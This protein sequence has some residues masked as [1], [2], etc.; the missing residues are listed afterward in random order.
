MPLVRHAVDRSLLLFAAAGCASAPAPAPAQPTKIDVAEP[1]PDAAAEQEAELAC[2]PA[3]PGGTRC[4]DNAARYC[5]EGRCLTQ[6]DCL[7]ACKRHHD[8]ASGRCIDRAR[9]GLCSDG[10]CSEGY[11]NAATL[12][13]QDALYGEATCAELSCGDPRPARELTGE[14]R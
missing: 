5:Y 10:E 2:D 4:G 3:A 9:E 7:A 13:A 12:C 6:Q 14:T 11:T 1:A 8:E